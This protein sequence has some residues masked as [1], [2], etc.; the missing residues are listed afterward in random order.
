MDHELAS[1]EYQDES[2][3]LTQALIVYRELKTRHAALRE[4]LEASIAA[5]DRGE[6]APLDIGAIKSELAA[7]LDESGEPT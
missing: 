1:G 5:A 7:E 3:L 4:D 6:V 2:E